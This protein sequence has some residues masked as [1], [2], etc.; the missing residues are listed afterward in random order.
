MTANPLDLLALECLALVREAVGDGTDPAPDHPQADQVEALLL[1]AM[2]TGGAALL[3]LARDAVRR[4]TARGPAAASWQTLFSESELRQLAD[5]IAAVLAAADGLGRQLVRDAADRAAQVREALEPGATSQVPS[6]RRAL[7]YLRGLVPTLGT[8][9]QRQGPDLQRRAFTMAVA[10]NQQLLTSVQG[11]IARRLQTGEAA[12]G[13]AAVRGILD[14]AGVSPRNPQYCFLPGTLVEGAVLA[15][16]KAW[17]DGPAVQ[18]ETDDGRRLS[19]T[20]N[21]PVLTATGWKRAGNVQQGEQLVCYGPAVE[22]LANQAGLTVAAFAKGRTVDHQQRPARIEDVF[23][24][25]H[26]E[27]SAGFHVE[28]PVAPLDFYGDGAFFKGDVHRVWA[29]RMLVQPVDADGGQT[30]QQ[31]D[32]VLWNIAPANLAAGTVGLLDLRRHCTSNSTL[33]ARKV[34][35]S[36]RFAVGRNLGPVQPHC[37]GL[38]ADLDPGVF[39][40]TEKRPGGD[41]QL[42]GQLVQRLPGLV[43]LRRVVNVERVWWTGHVYDLQTGTG[44]IV[45]QG[46][47]TSNCELVFRTNSMDAYNQA[48][49]EELTATADVFP[50]W[51]YSN[52][53]D[54][55]SR[56]EHKA[57]DGQYYPSTVPF[58]QVMGTE[59]GDV[60]NCRCTMIPITRRKWAKLRAEGKR[61]ADGYTDPLDVQAQAATA[62]QP[63]PTGPVLR[64]DGRVSPRVVQQVEQAM[65]TIPEAAH[66]VVRD[67]GGEVRVAFRL[68]NVNPA[69]SQ[70][71]PSGWPSG[72]TWD[73]ADGLYWNDGKQAIAAESYIPVGSK[74]YFASDRVA[75]VARHEYGHLID[76]AVGDMVGQQ[77]AR[78]YTRACTSPD[79]AAAYAD[80]VADLKKAGR[81]KAGDIDYYLQAGT[82]GPEE[83]FA[84]VLAQM[85]GGGAHTG[86]DIRPLFPRCMVAIQN[87]LAGLGP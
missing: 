25:L 6:P 41:V 29:D 83:A 12:G 64:V 79:F 31:F 76:H 40:A 38:A 71:Q 21:H 87:L 48:S 7:A 73:N 51:M 15:A 11:E 28:T 62:V 52:P 69:W 74:T 30:P 81:D 70:E 84:E 1:D 63:K 61:I 23:E 65:S 72:T 46:I 18:I 85:H 9:P 36:I 75:G 60:I 56:P 66:K 57:R 34:P 14:A 20:V 77:A 5:V 42:A 17:Y 78:P 33:A 55:R 54:S 47:I 22:S 43:S 4:M 8:D 80:D 27:C 24:T 3:A 53:H 35:Q 44:F 19:V 37:V 68:S 49:Q 13:E 26:M 45:S 59:P 50:V 82:R 10:T 32:L 86:T 39:Q 67:F 16:S 2:A 58:T